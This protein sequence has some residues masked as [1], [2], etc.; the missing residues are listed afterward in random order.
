MSRV[1]RQAEDS[2]EG[3]RSQGGRKGRAW[4]PGLSHHPSQGAGQAGGWQE[5]PQS[6]TLDPT[7]GMGTG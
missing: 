4:H 5:Q 2:S 7:L 6:R 1:P 3:W